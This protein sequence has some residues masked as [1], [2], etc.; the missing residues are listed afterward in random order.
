[1]VSGLWDV[2]SID[3]SSKFIENQKPLILATQIVSMRFNWLRFIKMRNKNTTKGRRDIDST[4]V[5]MEN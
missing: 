2:F 4:F 3:M 5:R 1:M